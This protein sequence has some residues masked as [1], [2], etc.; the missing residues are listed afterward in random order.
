MWRKIGEVFSLR[1]HGKPW[2]KSHAM[3]P[4]PL[5]MEKAIRVYFTTRDQTGMSRI[6]FADL[7]RNDPARVLHVPDRPLLEI[8]RPGT[9]DDSGT[10]SNFVM[11]LDG[12]VSLYYH[13]YNRR[14]V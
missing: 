1:E 12:R 14:V 8:G 9:F 5:L 7:D 10:L 11:A 6:S 4:T 2:M 3:L 13:G